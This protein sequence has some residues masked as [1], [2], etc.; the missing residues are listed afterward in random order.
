MI[1]MSLL[2]NYLE[3]ILDQGKADLVA[4]FSVPFPVRVIYDVMGF[5]DDISASQKFAGLA[6]TIL[7]G[8]DANPANAAAAAERAGAA[9]DELF[10]H[11]LPIV[12]QRRAE[13]AVGEDMIAHLLR[14]EQDGESFT[15]EQVTNFVRMMLI[16][17]TETT[18]RAFGNMM[19]HLI[20]RPDLMGRIRADRSLVPK[21]VTESLRYDTVSA[22]LARIAVKDTEI[23][24]VFI[25]AGTALSLA[26]GSANRDSAMFIDG[27]SYD[28]DRPLKPNIAFGSGVHTCLGMPVARIEL[29]TALN[30]VLDM[31][32]NLR[33]NPNQPEPVIK[34]LQLRGPDVLHVCW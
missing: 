29:E 18:M 1:R 12:R 5:P 10:N 28:I 25:A 11:V 13:G 26:T 31:M 7:S 9:S 3:P 22:F 32:P 34:G 17:A 14:V 16:A 20:R 8:F 2:S 33:F 4:D 6:L 24:G 30:L 21:A 23:A 15:D 27:D 19:I